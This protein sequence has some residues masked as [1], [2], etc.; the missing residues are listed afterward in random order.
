[1]TCLTPDEA[2]ALMDEASPAPLHALECGQC[3]ALLDDL[4]GVRTV[5]RRLGAAAWGPAPALDVEAALRRVH[6]RALAAR[7]GRQG[8][9]GRVPQALSAAAAAFLLCALLG[10]YALRQRVEGPGPT[11]RDEFRPRSGRVVFWTSAPSDLA[12]SGAPT[13]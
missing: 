11:R 9:A 2:R 5:A 4:R 13:D 1:M 7:L 6:G 10:P 3:A 8:G 12:L